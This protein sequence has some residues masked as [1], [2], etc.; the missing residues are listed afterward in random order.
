MGFW[1]VAGKV[2]KGAGK[3]TVAVGKEML[4]Q[5]QE[6]KQDR[7]NMSDES[8]QELIRI[9]KNQSGSKKTAAWAE[10]KDRGYSPDDIKYMMNGV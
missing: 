3:L 4:N 8:D 2:A 6:Y 7:E 9:V 1:D 5:G 10:L